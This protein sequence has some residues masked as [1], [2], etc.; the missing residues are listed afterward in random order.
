MKF[1]N[2]SLLCG[3]FVVI[4]TYVK[5]SE[6]SAYR[7]KSHI[8]SA[9]IYSLALLVWP[10]VWYEALGTQVISNK[11]SIVSLLWPII[12]LGFD[13]AMLKSNNDEVQSKKGIL[14]I[15]SNTICSLTFALAGILASQFPDKKVCCSKLFMYAIIGCL[16][17]ILPFSHSSSSSMEVVGLE[18]FQRVCLTFSTS[19]LIAG[20]LYMNS[21][22]YASIP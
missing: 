20:T 14:N 7:E 4:F 11:F 3:L 12:I 17:F 19:F 15:D 9:S 21:A 2:I 8:V 22:E 16:V 1:V 5:L 18:C 10:L 13:V 6:A